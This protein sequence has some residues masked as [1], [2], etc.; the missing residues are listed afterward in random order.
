MSV[1]QLSNWIWMKERDM[2]LR[3]GLLIIMITLLAGGAGAQRSE[4]A[5]T[6]PLGWNTWYAFGC[7]VTEANVK[8]T[9]DAMASNGMKA[10]GYE[11]ISLD[12]CWQGERDSE[13]HIHSNERFPDMKALG[14][15]IH[16]RGFKFGIYSS[17]G[18]KTCG[19]YIG[20]Y[21]HEKEDAE[22]YA[23]WGVDLVKYDWC[24]AR[25]VYKPDQIEVAYR[26]M[27][28]AILKT[29]RPM[30]YSLCEY[31]MG[32]PWMWG[33]KI[34]ANLWRTTDDVS[35]KIDFQEYA[36]MMFVGF[37]QEG[38]QH[39][40]GPGHWNDPDFLQIGN[41]GL[42]LDEDKTQMT[43]WSLLAAPLFSS[44]DVTKL[45]D[46]QLAVLTNRE[47]IAVDQDSKAIQ[48]HR[49]NQEGPVQIWVKPLSRGRTA[50]GLINSGESPFPASVSFSDI[51]YSHPVRVRDLWE[52]KDLG[53]FKNSYKTIVPKHGVVLIEIH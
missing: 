34:G 37:G 7:H 33:P 51:G 23:N 19:G 18:P 10:A 5:A 9:V 27:H 26:K 16:T 50:V 11:Y 21:G 6:P 8:A 24:S 29:G 14:D 12:D 45:T 52:Q 39:F 42:N 25:E 47:V 35:N 13:G 40:A 36:R 22:T 3:L 30:I 48:G 44:T 49:L 4:L 17:P 43:L 32:A 15:Y 28:D 41:L 20:S 1:L 31:G 2:S 46:T 38:L 53:T